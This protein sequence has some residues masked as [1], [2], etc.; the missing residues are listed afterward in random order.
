MPNKYIPLK[1][2]ICAVQKSYNSVYHVNYSNLKNQVTKWHNEL[3]NIKPY[4][5]VKSLPLENILKHL[6]SSNVNF[7]CASRGEIESVLK[8]SSPQNIVYANPSKSNDDIH[9]ANINKVDTMVVDS[10]EEIKKMDYINPNL[11]KIIRIKSVE[12]DSDIKFNSKF[13]ASEEEVFKM[14][15]YL[16][17]NKTFEGFS[18]HVGSK[19][20]NEESYF[21]TIKNVMD[22]YHNYCLKKNIPIKTI[23]IGGGFSSHTN[24]STLYKILNPFY[25]GF[26]KDNIKLIAEPGRFFAEPSVDLYCKV[27]A[28]K[29]R[30]NNGHPIYHVTINDSVYSTFN[31]KLFDSQKYTPIPLWDSTDNEWVDCVI[32]GQT[33]DSLD[34]ICNHIRLPLPKVDNVFKFK[35]MGAYSLAACY[36]RFNGFDEPKEI[37]LEIELN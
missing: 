22:N 37:D 12:S 20:K 14:L 17:S 21:L 11:K 4:Y 16:S 7:D 31:G 10:I 30:D 19:C 29:K 36:G 9:Y 24:L 13:G 28:V 3:P 23:D 18:F 8:F 34:V 33:C 27:I 32:F 25:D 5:A 6:A 26:K 2:L 1:K 15:E 35:N